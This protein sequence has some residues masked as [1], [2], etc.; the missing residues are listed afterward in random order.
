M[1]TF[2]GAGLACATLACVAATA[3]AHIVAS[4]DTAAAGGWFRTAFRVSHGCAGSPTVAVRIA[5]PDGVLMARAQAK[6]G[7]PVA[8]VKRPLPEPVPTGHGGVLADTTA[9]IV[10]RG[11]PLPDDQFDEFGVAMRL[12]DEPGRVLAFAVVQECREGRYDWVEVVKD[13]QDRRDLHH[14]APVVRLLAR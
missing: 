8:T 11:G 14:P 13:G 12:P 4:P 10:W 3:G 5:I 7:W 2:L 1:R 6:P 9:E